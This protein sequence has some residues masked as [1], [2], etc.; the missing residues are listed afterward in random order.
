MLINRTSAQWD[1]AQQL[2][3]CLT[4]DGFHVTV[5]CSGSDLVV[6]VHTN[7]RATFDACPKTWKGFEVEAVFVGPKKRRSA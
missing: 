1:A 5:T 4:K 3:E 6:Q 7:Q 2:E